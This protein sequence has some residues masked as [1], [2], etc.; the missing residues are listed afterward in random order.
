MNLHGPPHHSLATTSPDE[1]S[2]S[3]HDKG[4]DGLNSLGKL[5][6]VAMI[7]NPDE[8]CSAARTTAEQL[9]A[10]RHEIARCLPVG[11]SATDDERL[12]AALDLAITATGHRAS[13]LVAAADTLAA[14]AAGPAVDA[15]SGGSP[16]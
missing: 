1:I 7:D 8:V 15:A 5:A 2:T 4:N 16:R 14:H 13:A 12:A 6:H 9:M 10:I 3:T 11:L